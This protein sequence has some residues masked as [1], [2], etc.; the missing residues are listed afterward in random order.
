[1]SAPSIKLW[2]T[3]M[4]R[5][6][7][8]GRDQLVLSG[9]DDVSP[10]HNSVHTNRRP[11]FE[12]QCLKTCGIGDHSCRLPPASYRVSKVISPRKILDLSPQ[13]PHQRHPSKLAATLRAL[14]Q[15]RDLLLDNL[16]HNG[17]A[18]S[19]GEMVNLRGIT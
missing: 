5:I 16:G 12:R 11:G 6:G 17:Q 13:L 8:Y 14:E 4:T 1:M 15:T 7:G 19:F 9:G 10:P 18:K 2:A 3:G